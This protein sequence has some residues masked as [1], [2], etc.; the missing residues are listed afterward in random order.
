MTSRMKAK[1]DRYERDVRMLARMNGFPGAE[2]TKAGYERDAGDIHLDPRM[3]LGPGVIIQCKDVRTP[4]W[5]EWIEQ[6]ALQQ[7]ESKADFSFIALKR[8]R[9]GKAPLNLAVLPF[10][11][12][13][14]LLR[15]AGYGTPLE[16]QS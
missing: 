4:V 1:G 10:E 7:E 13:L 11:H 3:G 9:P 2:R 14:T 12:M 15:L 6:L 5:T 16:D 8:S